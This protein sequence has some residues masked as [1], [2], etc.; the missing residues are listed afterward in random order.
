[1]L[2][3]TATQIDAYNNA[4]AK[5]YVS[6]ALHKNCNAVTILTDGEVVMGYASPSVA[7]YILENA[8]YLALN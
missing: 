6:Q 3:F 1:M 7:K 5:F 2:L 8:N 4:S